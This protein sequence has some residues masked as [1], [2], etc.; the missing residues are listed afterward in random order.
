MISRR[1]ALAPHAAKL[2][3]LRLWAEPG[4]GQAVDVPFALGQKLP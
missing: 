4:R 2:L 1:A 3:T